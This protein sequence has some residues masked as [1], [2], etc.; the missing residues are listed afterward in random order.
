MNCPACQT[1]TRVIDSRPV[2]G[3]VRRRRVCQQCGHRFTTYE[4]A[5]ELEPAVVKQDGRPEPFQAAKVL[6][7]LRLACAKRP[8]P[9]GR[10]ES[11]VEVVRLRAAHSAAAEVSSA[12]IGE[13]VLEH[14]RALD[15]VAAFR[16][17]AVF[18]RPNDLDALGQELRAAAAPRPTPPAAV[19]GS[20]PLLPGMPATPAN[21]PNGRPAGRA[22]SQRALRQRAARPRSTTQ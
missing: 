11:L 10:L 7:S 4:R 2:E 13:W 6:R 15:A 12:E 3:S 20:Q 18:H 17:A 8:I 9:E 5:A 19:P 21:R 14:L 16:F 1:E 22:A